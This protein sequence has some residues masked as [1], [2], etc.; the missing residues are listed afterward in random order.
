VTAAVVAPAASAFRVLE[1]DLVAREPCGVPAGAAFF[2]VEDVLLVDF[3]DELEL[4][5][6]VVFCDVFLGCVGLALDVDVD[7]VVL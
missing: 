1:L 5:L 3:F 6:V 7:E 2:C 4:F